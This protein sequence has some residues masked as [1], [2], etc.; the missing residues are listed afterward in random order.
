MH[1]AVYFRDDKDRLY[2]QEKKEE[3]NLPALKIEMT[4]RLHKKARRKTDYSHQ[5][6]YRQH[7]HQPNKNNQKTR[8]GRKITIW[9]LQA[10][11]ERN[12]TREILDMAKKGKP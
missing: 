5:K 6:Q 3:K 8:M 4:R 9:T 7:K 11:N 1:K 2:L 12:L 10:T